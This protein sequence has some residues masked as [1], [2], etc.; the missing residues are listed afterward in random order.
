MI[1]APN[2]YEFDVDVNRERLLERV[3]LFPALLI[4]SGIHFVSEWD[5]LVIEW[6]QK[7]NLFV[8]S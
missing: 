1:Y 3:A 2:A 7:S 4:F 8:I 6:R 5:L